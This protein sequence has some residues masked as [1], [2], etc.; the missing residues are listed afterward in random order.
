MNSHP[1]DII[2]AYIKYP[3]G[4]IGQGEFC[5]VCNRFNTRYST[6]S[7][8]GINAKGQ[9]LLIKRHRNPEAGCWALPGGYLDWN[10]TVSQAATREFK[11]ETGII[12]PKVSFFKLYDNIHRDK[13]GRQNVDH[14]FIAKVPK[15]QSINIDPDEV[16]TAQWFS[17]NNLPENIAFD[18][19][20]MLADY[21][22]TL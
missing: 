3:T 5:P 12:L 22:S 20:Q 11:E 14:C 9:V 8:I 4:S 16:E 15:D 6:L 7:V 13:D 10:E 2:A 1:N 18:H 21:Q 17:F 19:G